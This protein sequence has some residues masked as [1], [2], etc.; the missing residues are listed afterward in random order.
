MGVGRGAEGERENHKQTPSNMQPDTRLN[1]TTLKSTWAKTTSQI[2]NWLS[3]SGASDIFFI[4]D[5]FALIFIFQK[6]Y[7][8]VSL[9][10]I[11]DILQGISDTLM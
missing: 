9:M 2:L 7:I 8:K 3:H 4:I 11:S 5:L 1:L 10:P 6:Y